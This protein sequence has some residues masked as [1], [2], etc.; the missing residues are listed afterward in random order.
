MAAMAAEGDGKGT[1]VVVGAGIAGLSAA[2]AI[3]QSDDDEKLRVLMLEARE[4]PGGR[5]FAT[6]MP[7]TDVRV[8]A[9]ASWIHGPKNNPATFLAQLYQ[10]DHTTVPMPFEQTSFS[11]AHHAASNGVVAICSTSCSQSAGQYYK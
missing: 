10:A 2:L 5:T 4:R 9:G 3:L 11:V 7:G 6:Q 8:D 1:V